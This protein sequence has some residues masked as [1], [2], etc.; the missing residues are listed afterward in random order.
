LRRLPALGKRLEPAP[1]FGPAARAKTPVPGKKILHR[2]I[3]LSLLQLNP[4]D[5]IQ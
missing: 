4:A 1:L 3:A 5:L 2:L